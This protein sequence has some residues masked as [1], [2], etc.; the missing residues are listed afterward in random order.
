M[1]PIFRVR[2][3]LWR[4]NE[5][6]TL[7]PTAAGVVLLGKNPALK[8]VQC[9]VLADQYS[10]TRI[11]SRPLAQEKYS[12]PIPHLIREILAFVERHTEHPT[13]VVGINNITLAEYPKRAVR[14]VL[15][16]SFAHRDYE[17]ASRKIRIEIFKDRL[18]VSSPG[19][20]PKPLTLAKLR[21]GKYESCRRNPVIAECLASQKLM[22]QRGTGFERIR[23]AMQDHGLD[24]HL[25]EQRDGY[26]KV[27]LPGP[28]GDFNRIRTPA[29]ARGPVKP[30]VQARMNER[31]KQIMLHVQTEGSVTSGWC[32]LKFGVTYNTAYRDLSGLVELGL[33]TQVGKGRATRYELRW[34]R[35]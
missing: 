23:A 18:V 27:I 34:E 10:D 20:P 26:F 32:R 3:L 33:L 25:L 22:E 29:E 2:G 24:A 17:D 19:Y 28:D 16:N 15:V 4:N 9:E 8:Y 13:R 30:S 6:D 1:I 21:S 11:T 31:Q 14:E 5:A 12:G 35:S 7:W